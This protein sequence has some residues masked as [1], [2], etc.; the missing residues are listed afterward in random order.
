MV[1]VYKMMQYIRNFLI[2]MWK[3]IKF[4][5]ELAGTARAADQLR[6]MGYYKEAEN[7]NQKIREM[8]STR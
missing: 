7:M 6:R 8:I 1:R 2:S 3:N 5:M 4:S